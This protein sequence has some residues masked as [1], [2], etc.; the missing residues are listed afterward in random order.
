MAIVPL[1]TFH[2]GCSSSSSPV[3]RVPDGGSPSKD[4]GHSDGASKEAG[5]RDGSP[6]GGSST[7]VPDKPRANVPWAPPSA[8]R[9]GACRADQTALY[10]SDFGSNNTAAF[11]SDPTNAMCD[12]CI[13][14]DAS[15]EEHGPVI[16][17]ALVQTNFGGCV[18]NVEANTSCGELIDVYELCAYEECGDCIDW[19]SGGPMAVACLKKAIAAGGACASAWDGKVESCVNELSSGK[20]AVCGAL[21]EFLNLWCGPSADGG[22]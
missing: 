22:A 18:D 11:R 2:S 3:L 17:G 16:L 7:C 20:T 12:A 9:P 13:E 15:A 10:L 21:G 19:G 5:A 6:E 8:F 14:T 4:G 1:V